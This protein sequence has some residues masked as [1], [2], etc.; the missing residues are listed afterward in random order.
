[1]QRFMMVVPFLIAAAAFLAMLAVDA[2]GGIKISLGVA[3]FFAW[4]IL[5]LDLWF[6]QK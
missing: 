6:M 2:P 3:L 4:L 1:M 5:I